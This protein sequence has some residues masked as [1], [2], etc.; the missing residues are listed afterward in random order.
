MKHLRLEP[1][2]AAALLPIFPGLLEMAVPK[3][4]IHSAEASGSDRPT[5]SVS[6]IPVPH[7][8]RLLTPANAIIVNLLVLSC[9]LIPLVLFF[10]HVF[11]VALM[12]KFVGNG[13]NGILLAVYGVG[14]AFL[15]LLVMRRLH[16]S[17]MRLPF[18]T[19]YYRRLFRRQL[20]ERNDA[21]VTFNEPEVCFIE[22]IPRTNWGKAAL[23]N[24]ADMGLLAVDW[25]RRELR[26]E[27]DRERW[28]IPAEAI[29][30][31]TVELTAGP[32]GQGGRYITVLRARLPAGEW[33]WPLAPRAGIP[34]ADDGERVETLCEQ[35][36]GLQETQTLIVTST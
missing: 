8:G 25:R 26:F 35:I 18:N 11:L 1:E 32:A 13:I 6:R 20:A 5:A 22:I 29:T 9:N 21:L 23:E 27:G 3:V 36:A 28:R 4:A 19:R 24:A 33:E 14:G 34:G 10:A 15:P 7:G 2:E 31:C 12:A 30:N 17:H 16:R